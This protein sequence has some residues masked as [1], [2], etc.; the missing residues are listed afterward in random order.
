[1]DSNHQLLL[2][3]TGMLPL[4]H[5][6]CF[7]SIAACSGYVNSHDR[8]KDITTQRMDDLDLEDL[9]T[10]GI[11]YACVAV[12]RAL[13]GQTPVSAL[14]EKYVADVKAFSG[15]QSE[16]FD[17]VMALQTPEQTRCIIDALKEYR[18]QEG[19]GVHEIVRADQ[20]LRHVLQ[21]QQK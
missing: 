21:K 11:H 2:C 16:V 19:L 13:S 10:S 1:M 5:A 7:A 6:P 15:P 17:A 8:E 20:A 12:A 18:F 3:T 4:H 9:D 14:R